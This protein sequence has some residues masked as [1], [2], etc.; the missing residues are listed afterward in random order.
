MAL[1][2]IYYA[3]SLV[4]NSNLQKYPVFEGSNVI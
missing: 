4:F 1:N 2:K 3:A